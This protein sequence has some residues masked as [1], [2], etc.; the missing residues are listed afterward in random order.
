LP[1]FFR[2]KKAGRRKGETQSMDNERII[3]AD[4]RTSKKDESAN[5]QIRLPSNQNQEYLLSK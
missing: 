1:P 2:L 3:T 5:Q 4:A